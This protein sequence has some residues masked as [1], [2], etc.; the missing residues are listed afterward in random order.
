MSDPHSLS[1]YHSFHTPCVVSRA[2]DATELEDFLDNYL[3]DNFNLFADDESPYEI[4]KLICRLYELIVSD[5]V[6]EA[7]QLLATPVAS[8]DAC[9][10]QVPGVLSLLLLLLR[11]ADW[12]RVHMSI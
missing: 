7:Q 3:Q 4:S 12:A 11:L 1:S 9:V 8:L 2:P 6:A 10:N 5:R